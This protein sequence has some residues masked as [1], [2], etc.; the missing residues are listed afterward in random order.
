MPNFVDDMTA[1]DFPKVKLRESS[2]PVANKIRDEDWNRLCQ[3]AID[4]RGKV[5]AGG[6]LFGPVMSAVPTAANT[7]FSS[8]YYQS[9]GATVSDGPL[10]ISLKAPTAGA[11]NAWVARMRAV[12]AAT[13][14]VK[15]LLGL[16]SA[17]INADA[18][19]FVAWADGAVGKSQ[20]VLWK[21]WFTGATWGSFTNNSPTTNLN[22]TAGSGNAFFTKNLVWLRM[23]DDGTNVS[24]Y[25][26]TTGQPDQ[27]YLVWTTA[28][29][30]G[31]LGVSGYSN[32]A[33]GVNAYN[34]AS[35]VSLLSWEIE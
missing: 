15:M 22:Y 27:F 12:P 9:G 16:N 20:G 4:L 26:S 1:L 3:A 10:G 11:L 7:G 24:V 31:H 19:A 30:G 2:V 33:F 25:M 35:G 32:I 21:P 28:K 23:T 17:A 8:W 29:S 34:G 13:Y 5:I 18:T 6:G 14:S